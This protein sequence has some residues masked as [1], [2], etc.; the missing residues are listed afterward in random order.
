M[1]KLID[2]LE[3]AKEELNDWRMEPRGSDTTAE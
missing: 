3:A 1:E 2:S